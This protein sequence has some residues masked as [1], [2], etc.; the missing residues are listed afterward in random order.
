MSAWTRPQPDELTLYLL[1]PGFGESMVIVLPKGEV[2]VVDCCTAG[3]DCLTL[4]LLSDLGYSTIDLL[5][6]THPDLDH[7]GGLERLLQ[8]ST[9][10]QAWIY[11]H[12]HLLRDLIG[13]FAGGGPSTQALARAWKELDKL[14]DRNQCMSVAYGN[15]DWKPPSGCATFSVLAPVSA[16]LAEA[17]KSLT[18]MIQWSNGKPELAPAMMDRLLGHR[19]NDHP[20]LVSLAVALRCDCWKLLLAG[21]L[22]SPPNAPYRGWSGVL[23]ELAKSGRADLVSHLDVVKLA[24]HGSDGAWHDPSWDLHTGGSARKVPLALLTPFNRGT[25][26]PPHVSALRSLLA[27]AERLAVPCERAEPCALAAGWAVGA[28]GGAGADGVVLRMSTTG[29]LDVLPQGRGTLYMPGP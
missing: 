3:D 2:V 11:P 7:V 1:G 28:C 15:M 9:V 18:A 4:M 16:D 27:R 26:P 20:N 29:R 25:N 13:K 14:R 23:S 8:N 22:E 19:V 6:V 24:H 17:E 5:V 10:K 12:F 21:D